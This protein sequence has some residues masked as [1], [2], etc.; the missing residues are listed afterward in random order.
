MGAVGEGAEGTGEL[1]DG[2]RAV[3]ALGD[4]ALPRFLDEVGFFEAPDAHATPVRSGHDVDRVRLSAIR[5]LEFVAQSGDHFEET[6]LGFAGVD[7]GIGEESVARGVAGGD[8]FAF[9]RDRARGIGSIGG[10]GEFALR[11][12]GAFGFCAVGPECVDAENG[13]HIPG[14]IVAGG[15]VDF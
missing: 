2:R 10:G 3:I 7:Q 13:T 6:L 5:G 9:G 1:G 14:G 4:E 15:E 11:G 8:G 12:D